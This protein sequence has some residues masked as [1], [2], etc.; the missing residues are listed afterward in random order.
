MTAPLPTI[1]RCPECSRT[2]WPMT[3]D[4]WAQHTSPIHKAGMPPFL[5]APNCEARPIEIPCVPPDADPLSILALVG[6][7]HAAIWFDCEDVVDVIHT[8][9]PGAVDLRKPLFVFVPRRDA[10]TKG[11]TDA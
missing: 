2:Y 4:R 8:Q 6:D 7:V 5:D 11:T 3:P 10:T 1:W 9:I